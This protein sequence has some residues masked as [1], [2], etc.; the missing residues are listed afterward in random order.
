MRDLCESVYYD[1][2]GTFSFIV[3]RLIQVYN[4]LVKL[5][6]FQMRIYSILALFIGIIASAQCVCTGDEVTAVNGVTYCI[7]P[8]PTCGDGVLM[9]HDFEVS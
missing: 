1:Y 9:A 2:V 7:Y 6:R 4:Y 5:K 8:T 3:L